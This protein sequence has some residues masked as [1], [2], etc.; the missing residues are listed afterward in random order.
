MRN[1]P[2]QPATSTRPDSAAVDRLAPARPML[3]G[4][5][6]TPGTERLIRIVVNVTG[7]AFA[8]LFARASLK[9]YLS[10]HSLVGGLF[11]IEQAW[12]AAAFLTRR[13]PRTVNRRPWNWLLA[14]G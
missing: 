7:A 1:D 5:S 9:F 10:T 12:F 14:G 8:V 6:L 11:V 13:P 2:H 3:A 4:R